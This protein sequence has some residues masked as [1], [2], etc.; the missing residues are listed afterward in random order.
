MPPPAWRFCLVVVRSSGT[1][2]AAVGSAVHVSAPYYHRANVTTC[3]EA[4]ANPCFASG[5]ADDARNRGEEC[6]ASQALSRSWAR[7][8]P[9]W[10]A[11]PAKASSLPARADFADEAE[12]DRHGPWLQPAPTTVA[13]AKDPGKREAAAPNQTPGD[14]TNSTQAGDGHCAEQAADPRLPIHG[15]TGEPARRFDSSSR[16]RRQQLDGDGRRDRL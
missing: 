15:E 7:R 14:V 8:E 9:D 4:K 5:F 13:V 12:P 3:C 1:R 11:S 16:P 10:L 6:L 2:R